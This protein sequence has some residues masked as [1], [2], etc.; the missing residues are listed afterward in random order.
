MNKTVSST[1]HKSGGVSNYNASKILNWQEMHQNGFLRVR[2]THTTFQ[3]Q[4]PPS[5]NTQEVACKLE[6]VGYFDK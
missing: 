3:G 4:C 5:K 2:S 6:N 1:V